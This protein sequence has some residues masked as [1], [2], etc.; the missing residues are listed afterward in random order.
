MLAGEQETVILVLEAMV[1]WHN[2][3]FIN[4]QIMGWC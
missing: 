2:F 1:S 3:S 4:E